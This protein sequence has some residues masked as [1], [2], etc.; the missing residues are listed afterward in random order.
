MKHGIA[1]IRKNRKNKT[2]L[3]FTT[4]GCLE[5]PPNCRETLTQEKIKIILPKMN[6]LPQ[7]VVEAPF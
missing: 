1:R 5:S 6:A 3:G 4:Y 2:T 7:T